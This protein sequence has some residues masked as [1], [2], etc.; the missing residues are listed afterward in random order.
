MHT[1]GESTVTQR[2]LC[3]GQ[4]VTKAGR[5]RKQQQQE[6]T[7]RNFFAPS[8]TFR[9]TAFRDSVPPEKSYC[10]LVALCLFLSPLGAT[11]VGGS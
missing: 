9:F 11:S 7:S 6:E 2:F 8:L 10:A 3:N 1:Q 4:S 5:R